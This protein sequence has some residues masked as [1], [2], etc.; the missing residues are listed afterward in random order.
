MAAGQ[1]MGFHGK[2]PG[3]GDF[4]RRRVS[5]DFLER[6]D[7]G[8]ERCIHASR[9]ALGDA[10]LDAYLTSPIW[11]FALGRGTCGGA[12]TGVLMPSV[13]AVGRYYP[14]TLVR[15]LP[16]GSTLLTLPVEDSDWFETVEQL[17]L[18]ALEGGDDFDLGL[19]DQSVH[20]IGRKL[21]P[22][23]TEETS[24]LLDPLRG[25][26]RF[27]LQNLSDVMPALLTA[28]QALASGD[29]GFSLWW[30][31]GSER[32]APCL[33]ML[34]GLPQPEQFAAMIDGEWHR[35]GWDSR[36]VRW[37]AAT[38]SAMDQAE[39]VEV[40]LNLRSAAQTHVGK[41]RQINEDA[42]LDRPDLGLWAVADGVGG[43]D[44]G[45]VA[46]RAVVDSLQQVRTGGELQ[47]RLA[48]AREMLR[49]TNEH[50]ACAASRP[51]KPVRSAS[52]VVALFAGG[53]ECAWLWAGDSRLYRLRGGELTRCT[54]DHSLVQDM[55]DRGELQEAQA[56]GH[57]QAN[58]ITRAVGAAASL[59]LEHRYSDLQP[60]DRYLL[61]SD[62]IHGAIEETVI[63]RALRAESPQ[64]AVDAL[65]AAVLG[66][67]AKDNCT[68]VAVFCD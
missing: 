57:P 49:L 8:L 31:E 28:Q 19:F 44:A 43:H 11:R 51:D 18:S 6:W 5:G 55:V 66:G 20:D 9:R 42:W 10:W 32:I 3:R 65:T 50:L 13:D 40:P 23:V 61:C 24:R 35:H 63:A 67:P 12:C 1:A 16:G 47:E 46:S 68:A 33:F 39:L 30:T 59:E 53:H 41:V 26:V 37:Q 17:A 2:L 15:P 14:L 52:T 48:A 7:P 60:G 45:D 25:P 58:V 56:A 36:T 22:R 34:G 64:G 62:G 29:Q 27:R 38:S 21:A 4:V 54:R